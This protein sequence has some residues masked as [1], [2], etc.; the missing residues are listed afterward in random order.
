LVD[1]NGLIYPLF[2]CR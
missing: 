2:S 1:I